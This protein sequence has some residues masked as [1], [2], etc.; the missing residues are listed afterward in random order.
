MLTIHIPNEITEIGNKIKKVTTNNKG[1]IV[2]NGSDQNWNNYMAHSLLNELILDESGSKRIKECVTIPGPDD[3]YTPQWLS[4]PVPLEKLTDNMV[5]FATAIREV[6][7]AKDVLIA[8]EKCIV[9]CIVHVT[10]TEDIVG[11]FVDMGVNKDDIVKN[12]VCTISREDTQ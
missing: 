10:S 8:A 7:K 9:I 6:Q 5:V 12:L 3:T 1:L 11:R 4:A 2:I